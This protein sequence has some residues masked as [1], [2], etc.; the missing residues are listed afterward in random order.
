[1][2]LISWNVNGIRACFE[3][4]LLD[5]L[6]QQKPDI[7]CLQETKAHPEQLDQKILSSLSLGGPMYFSSA[8]KKGYSGVATLLSAKTLEPKTVS[9]EMGI[10]AYDKEGRFMITDHKHFKLY[11]IYFPNGGMN[12]QRHLLKQRFLK[13]LNAHLK[14]EIQKKPLI[15]VGDYNVAYEDKDVYDPKALGQTSGFL[16]E[17]R[18]WFR[19]FLELGFVDL[20]RHFYPQKQTFT[21]W[22]Y[23]EKARRDNRGWRIDLVCVSKNLLKKVEKMKIFDS[24]HGSDHCPLS[25]ELRGV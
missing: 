12:E 10:R 4:G 8:Y 11:N 1:M 3:K 17:E 18:Q 2:K 23:R 6:Q 25:V 21:W 9:Q 7:C 19:S 16:P 24:Q 22:S 15:V 20:F 5:F 13:N 14:K